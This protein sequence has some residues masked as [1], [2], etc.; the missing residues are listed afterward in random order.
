MIHFDESTHT[1]RN[2]AGKIYVSGTTLIGKYKNPFDSDY[3][4][5]YKTIEALTTEY[6]SA[7]IFKANSHLLNKSTIDFYIKGL[8]SKYGDDKVSGTLS[9]IL[10][11][12]KHKKEIGCNRGTLVHLAKEEK[13]YVD[14]GLQVFDNFVDLQ[15]E[16]RSTLELKDGIYPELR[17][18]NHEYEIAGTADIV[19]IEG[20]YF[21]IDDYKTNKKIVTEA[22]TNK[23]TGE[24]DNML[25]PISHLG[26]CNFI[27][28]CLQLNL[29]AWMLVQKGYILRNL[30]FTHLLTENET[31]TEI[32][33]TKVYDVP[34]LQ[35]EIKAI[36]EHF[37]LNKNGN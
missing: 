26:N 1:Y 16:G 18:W 22:F 12:W 5:K 2:D 33:G 4:S 28:Y 3:W 32:V 34:N 19:I 27:H 14:K 7:E 9:K 36:L 8:T 15:N 24:E 25:F 13:T 11:S 23:R 37:K 30:R 10:E 31:T 21:D 35:E 29:Y 17:L 20:K 6:K